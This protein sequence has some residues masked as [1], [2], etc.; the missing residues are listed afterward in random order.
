MEYSSIK[1]A[2]S[3]VNN[4]QSA[5]EDQRTETDLGFIGGSDFVVFGVI[6]LLRLPQLLQS[7]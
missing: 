2:A 7:I 3:L 1:L 6:L 5:I 4:S